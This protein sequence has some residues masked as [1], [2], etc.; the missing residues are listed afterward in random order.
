MRIRRRKQYLVSDQS[1]KQISALNKLI[2]LPREIDLIPLGMLRM[3]NDTQITVKILTALLGAV[4]LVI[5]TAA[6]NSWVKDQSEQK[7]KIDMMFNYVLTSSIKDSLRDDRISQIQA[8]MNIHEK[9]TNE[10]ISKLYESL[11]NSQ[12][13][14]SEKNNHIDLNQN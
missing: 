5:F 2:S 3:S 1:N 10:S 6:V 11:Y 13:Q 14:L 7:A 8:R 9:E 4:A 12:K